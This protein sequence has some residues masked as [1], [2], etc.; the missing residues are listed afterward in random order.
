MS[1]TTSY[2]HCHAGFATYQHA[3]ADSIV[4]VTAPE[5]IF[6][7]GLKIQYTQANDHQPGTHNTTA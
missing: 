2:K 5:S 1:T 7:L 3:I 6:L 4:K